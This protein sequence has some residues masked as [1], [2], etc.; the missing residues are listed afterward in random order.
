MCDNAE[1]TDIEEFDNSSVIYPNPT[2]GIVSI[3]LADNELSNAIVKVYDMNGKLVNLVPTMSNDKL[4][5]DLSSL[6]SGLYLISI[7]TPTQTITKKISL[8]K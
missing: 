5:L 1:T 8:I 6:R 2:T 7:Q 4:T 3:R